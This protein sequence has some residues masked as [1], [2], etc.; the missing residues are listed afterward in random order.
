M[1]SEFAKTAPPVFSGHE[2]LA[3]GE[4]RRQRNEATIHVNESSLSRAM[5]MEITL[6]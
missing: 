3:R 2:I 6:T 5:L 1:V 4:L